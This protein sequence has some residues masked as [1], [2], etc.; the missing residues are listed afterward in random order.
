MKWFY[1]L[2][3][4]TKLLSSF[5]LVALI[6]ASIGYIG[7]TKLGTL[8]AAGVA[9]YELNTKPLGDL[10]DVT[11]FYQ[12]ERVN[13]RD[14][15][16]DRTPEDRNKHLANI[17]EL[18]KQI[19]A[20]LKLVDENSKSPEIK[21]AIVDIHAALN[22]YEPVWQK[23]AGLVL[24]GKTDEAFAAMRDPGNAQIAKSVDDGIQKL[25]D[26]KVAD[27]KKKSELNAE[28]AKSA[29]R[30]TLILMIAGSLLAVGLGLFISSIISGPL[31]RGVEFVQ[32]VAGGDL[33]QQI[34]L[35][36][37]DEVGKL[38]QAMNLMVEKLRE[39]VGEVKSA[40]DYVA[41]GSQ[42][43]SSSSEEMSQGA[44]E[45]AAAAEE[46]SSSMEQMGS[47]IRQNADNAL[48]TE[49]IANK[50]AADA[51]EGGQ[52]V[53]ETVVAMKEIAGK[54]NIIEEIARQ[55]NLLALNAAIE[56][57]RAGEHGKGFA[58]VATE[59]RKLAERSQHAA[60]EISELSRHSVDIAVKA[61]ELLSH[62]VPD[63]QRTAELVQE[64]SASSKEQ[65]TGAEQIN[66]AIQQL[67]QVIQQNAG[68][69]EEMS[70]TSE[71]LASQAEQ[72]QSTISFFT[73]DQSRGA[74]KLAATRKKAVPKVSFAQA[75][76]APV[77]Q[78][79]GARAKAVGAD[80]FMDGPNDD[81]FEKF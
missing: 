81:G 38:A 15:F 12:R 67:D 37:E 57:A 51:R 74:S 29:I 71:E 56:A 32:A 5:I 45:Q 54:I 69:A 21:K 9:M 3:V 65:D 68:A 36:Q 23:I 26:L 18:D 24:A 44:S 19:S 4:A 43:L 10:I 7:I 14:L 53:Q 49:K 1:N 75:S 22:A 25:S 33:T 6:A 20:T 70:S 30:F 40:T 8:Q 77:R 80:L 2:K 62:M 64:I 47:N 39:I 35:D 28:T 59:V 16:I 31:R 34:N 73:T 50:S 13:V 27:A 61:G 76:P 48:Q 58:V 17:K 11:T 42:Q 55:T 66:K 46:V 78:N 79:S 52:A 60:A 72:L 41:S 63:I